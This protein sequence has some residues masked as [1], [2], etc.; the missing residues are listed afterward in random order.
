MSAPRHQFHFLG[1]HDTRWRVRLEL[2]FCPKGVTM[3]LLSENGKPLGPAQVAPPEG[4]H[5]FTVELSG[6]CQLPAGAVVRC[7]IDT[8]CGIWIKDF[9]LD[10]RRGLHAFLHADAR[11]PVD[12]SEPI[13]ALSAGERG[14]LTELLPWMAHTPKAAGCC[15]GSGD[16]I[17]MLKDFGV[18]VD[19]L[20]SGLK[21]TLAQQDGSGRR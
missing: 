6:P 3:G 16:L 21:E 1:R 19:A 14:R 4:R 7:T 13:R 9:P 20:D 11:L 15:E 17:G 18:D 8:E 10:Q 2:G 5:S 12:S